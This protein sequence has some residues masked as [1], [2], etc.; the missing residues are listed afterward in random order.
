MT[1][2]QLVTVAVFPVRSDAEIARARLESAGITAL[3]RADDEGGL[4]PGFF[5]HYGVRVEVRSSEA[6]DARLLLSSPAARPV[7]QEEMVDAVIA[8]ARFTY[9]EEACGLFAVDADGSPRMVYCLTNVERSRTRFT[10]DPNEHF[11][12]WRHAE[13]NGWD[14][15]GV[16]HSHPAS[17]PI[18]SP[19]DIKG[20]LD[21]DWFHVIVSLVDPAQPEVRM[22]SIVDGE[23]RE[24]GP[25]GVA[26]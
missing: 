19:T 6:E 3:V 22:F 25:I 13:R 20:A 10:V 18:P 1:D 2:D 5:S 4:N 12:A 11:R 8:H 21:P 15:G 26:E 9:P 17:P 23:A 7:L 16:F 24:L 14:I